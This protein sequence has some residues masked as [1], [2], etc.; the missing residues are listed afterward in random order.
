V[1]EI[2]RLQKWYESQ[3]NGERE[4]QH[5]ISINSC[6]NPGWWVK[7]DVAGTSLETKPFA[8]VARNVDPEQ[9][10]RIA[11]GLEP[12]RCDRGTDWM[13]CEVKHKVFEGAGDPGKLQTILG[14]F[15]NWATP[16]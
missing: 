2:T 11:R 4:H 5:G 12:D 13:L 8:T 6:D 3:C 15:L 7:I 14:A 10:A 9:I 16:E 1:N